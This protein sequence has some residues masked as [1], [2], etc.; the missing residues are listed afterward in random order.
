M[1][2]WLQQPRPG[3][4]QAWSSLLD[5][6]QCFCRRNW[7]IFIVILPV[8]E[9]RLISQ[10]FLHSQLWPFLWSGM[11]IAFSG[12]SS[13]LQI[14]RISPC[15]REMRISPPVLIASA[16]T[17]SCLGVFQFICLTSLIV[18]S[19]SDIGEWWGSISG[20][21]VVGPGSWLKRPS[22]ESFQQCRRSVA[23]GTKVPFAFLMLSLVEF[24]L[25]L[26]PRN[27]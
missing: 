1:K 13:V 10:Y 2:I 7:M 21:T 14:S 23:E 15:S 19:V 16:A 8:M 3:R 9:R 25:S 27:M 22:E 18:G 24:N 11:T 5:C 20:G 12:I 26:R 6:S 17:W 4:K